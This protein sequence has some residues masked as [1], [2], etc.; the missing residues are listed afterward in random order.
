[1]D[2]AEEIEKRLTGE[3]GPFA[4]EEVRA[5]GQSFL[6]YRRAPCSLADIYRKARSLSAAEFLIWG[7]DRLSYTDTLDQ[8]AALARGLRDRF[9]LQ[10][11][12]RVV[13]ALPNIPEAIISLIATSHLGA[14]AVLLNSPS[15]DTESFGS[16]PGGEC[17]LISQ[18]RTTVSP[19]IVTVRRVGL[20]GDVMKSVTMKELTKEKGCWG[21]AVASDPD[22]IAIIAFTSGSTGQPKGVELTHRGIIAGLMNMMLAGNL[23]NTA[24]AQPVPRQRALP[25]RPRVVLIA[26]LSH[27]SGYSQIL[28][29]MMIGGT[30]ILARTSTPREVASIIQ[31]EL[32]RSVVGLTPS[33]IRSLL[34]LRT[35]F[36]LGSLTSFHVNG[37]ALFR[38]L[39]RL[40]AAELPHVMTWTSYGM[41]ETNG[42]ICALAGNVLEQQP[43]CVGR[44]VPSVDIEIFNNDGSR[45]GAGLPG[46]IW[47][48]GAM[49][50]RGYCGGG[51][52]EFEDGWFCT[53]DIGYVSKDRYL[54][55]LGRADRPLL[56]SGDEPISCPMI[57]EFVIETLGAKDATIFPMD[58]S[59]LALVV[60]PK[61]DVE[62]DC[63]FAMSCIQELFGISLA[64]Y[65]VGE[66]PRNGPGK[67]DRKLLDTLGK[68]LS[69]GR[70]GA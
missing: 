3:A 50:M 27:I 10:S 58:E 5:G 67:I 46:Q 19:D 29:Q 18:E 26:P 41:T 55:V 39:S 7:E 63:E 68:T 2:K 69:C 32:P 38:S 52:R 40:I 9:G 66:I 34:A 1:M 13:I 35:E 16:S 47:I 31:R 42:A 24:G 44:I 51:G 20:Q 45:T 56:T 4:L 60:V 22:D 8:A 23:A 64:V 33:L 21:A 25:A 48:R 62:F 49:L 6:A 14:I 30:V 12:A 53:G 36:D 59:N 15:R 37:Y 65:T 17:L 28:L 43:N 61:A 54:F 11:G 57:E 70:S